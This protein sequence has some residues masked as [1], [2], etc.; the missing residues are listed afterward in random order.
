MYNYQVLCNFRIFCVV[1]VQ[2]KYPF[3]FQ[4]FDIQPTMRVGTFRNVISNT[5]GLAVAEDYGIF[6]GLNDRG[7]D[8]Y[9]SS[10]AVCSYSSPSLLTNL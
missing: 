8:I 4:T 1:H 2:I 6:F 9:S 10:L 3:V 7:S 5:L